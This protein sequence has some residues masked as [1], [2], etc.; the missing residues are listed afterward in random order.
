MVNDSRCPIAAHGLLRALMTRK[1]AFHIPRQ[2]PEKENWKNEA[3]SEIMLFACLFVCL[4]V[5]LFVSFFLYFVDALPRCRHSCG[6]HPC[7]LSRCSANSWWPNLRGDR[8]PVTR[9][10]KNKENRQTSLG[11]SGISQE[12]VVVNTHLWLPVTWN[13]KILGIS[14]RQILP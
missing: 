12:N 10:T 2:R 6:P 9:G 5:C 3:P 7:I 8:I 14:L 11:T 4:L 1:L 13:T